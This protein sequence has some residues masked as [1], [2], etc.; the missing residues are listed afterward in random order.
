MTTDKKIPYEKIARRWRKNAAYK[1]AY[2]ALAPEYALYE[3]MLKAMAD[4]KLTQKE[5]ARRMHTSE[6]AISRMFDMKK[7]HTPSWATIM[8]FAHAVGKK[9]ILRF[10]DAR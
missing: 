7:K 6:S 10:V 9:P 3:A 4:A 1:A 2:E 5:V 8:K